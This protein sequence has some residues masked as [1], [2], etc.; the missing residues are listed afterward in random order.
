MEQELTISK[1]V[2]AKLYESIA[3]LTRLRRRA[4]NFV[5]DHASNLIKHSHKFMQMR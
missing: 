2:F 1:Y 4:W 5:W 3:R